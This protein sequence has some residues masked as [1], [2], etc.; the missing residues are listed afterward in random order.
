MRQ[1]DECHCSALCGIEIEMGLSPILFGEEHVI[2]TKGLMVP[3]QPGCQPIDL[4]A[5]H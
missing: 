4:L 5:A 1:V 2:L 3:I